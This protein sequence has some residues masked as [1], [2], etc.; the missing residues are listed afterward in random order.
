MAAM[1]EQYA[2]APGKPEELYARKDNVS[3]FALI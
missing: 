1:D 2:P 3:L